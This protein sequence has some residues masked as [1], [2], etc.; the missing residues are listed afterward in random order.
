MGEANDKIV[1]IYNEKSHDDKTPKLYKK[2]V[3][4]RADEVTAYN[5]MPVSTKLWNPARPG[6]LHGT[7]EKHNPEIS[8]TFSLKGSSLAHQ[9]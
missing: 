3:E 1:H 6:A 7:N 9:I 2:T 5:S 8:K 4:M